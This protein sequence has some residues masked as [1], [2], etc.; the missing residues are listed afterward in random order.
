MGY[1]RRIKE[2]L[3][4]GCMAIFILTSLAQFV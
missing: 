3:F 1:R 2:K 4:P